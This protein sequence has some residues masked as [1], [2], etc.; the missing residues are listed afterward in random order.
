MRGPD[1]LKRARRKDRKSASFI[2]KTLQLSPS[3]SFF[4]FCSCGLLRGPS[5]SQI[6][7]PCLA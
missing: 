5:S 7:F 4:A 3:S 1:W 2:R 6:D